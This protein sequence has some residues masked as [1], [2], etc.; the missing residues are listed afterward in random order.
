MKSKTRLG[1]GIAALVLLFWEVVGRTFE[2][3]PDIV[4]TPSRILLE[5][6]RLSALVRE[7]ASITVLE[8]LIG[9]LLAA[10][11]GVLLGALLASS[12]TLAGFAMPAVEFL[13][14]APVVVLAP[15]FFVWFGFGPLPKLVAPLIAGLF[16]VALKTISGLRSG[17]R[18]MDDFLRTTESGLARAFFKVRFPLALPDVF[19]GLR[20]AIWMSLL[21][22]VSEEFVAAD[23]GLGYLM[24][25]GMARMNTP[26]I[27]ASLV[28]VIGIGVVL[29]AGV[30][31]LQAVLKVPSIRQAADRIDPEIAPFALELKEREVL[32][33]VGPQGSGKTPLV[34]ATAGLAGTPRQRVGIVFSDPA[35]LGWRTVM[36]NILLQVELRGQEPAEARERARSLVAAMGLTGFE[37]NKPGELPHG[38]AHRVA[39]CRA[40]VHAPELLVLDDPF[41]SLDALVREQIAMELQR[42]LLREPV[43]VVFATSQIEEAVQLGDRVLVLSPDG[44]GVV[45]TVPVNLPRPRRM[46]KATSP[47]IVETSNRIR[48]IYHGLGVFP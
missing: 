16:P 32:A 26:L 40:L 15:L 34:R 9:F 45:E 1:L 8:V 17:S 29:Q 38:M 25:A 31:L 37:D 27:F 48:T 43:K 30:A 28:I 22:A 23:R 41:E 47:A 5:I 39:I 36:E 35:L 12:S 18:E 19:V 13:R 44:R 21:A 7:N 3:R 24:I 10:V 42:L 4:P 33:I 6:G 11:S 20:V 14:L 46:D 2:F